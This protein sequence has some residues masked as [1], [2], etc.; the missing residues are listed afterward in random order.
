MTFRQL[1]VGVALVLLFP[2]AVPAQD[3]GVMESAETINRG[4]FKLGGNP[5]IFVGRDGAANE[6][7]A[8]FKAGYGFTDSFDAEA[9]LGLF[10]NVRFFGG[11]VEFWL[12]KNA[13]LD[14]SLSAGL[15]ALTSDI[16]PDRTGADLT[17]LGSAPIA[18]NLEL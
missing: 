15:H 2:A 9:K 17:L 18:R 3:F 7:G 10:E 1:A 11:D 8:A 6:V 4:N 16:F 12:L 5:M 14:F 13:P